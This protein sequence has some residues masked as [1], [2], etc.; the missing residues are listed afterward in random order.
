MPY[1]C[2]IYTLIIYLLYTWYTV[3]TTSYL[4]QS[5]YYL[6]YGLSITC[7]RTYLAPQEPRTLCQ[8]GS[9]RGNER[10]I[11]WRSLTRCGWEPACGDPTV[12]SP[13]SKDEGKEKDPFLLL[14]V[15]ED[16]GFSFFFLSLLLCRCAHIRTSS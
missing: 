11:L 2:L 14:L 8:Q 6:V 9:H 3:H 1:I 16:I 4:Y 10:Y 13:C 7:M 12:P 15:S 5:F